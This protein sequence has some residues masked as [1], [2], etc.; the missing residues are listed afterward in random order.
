MTVPNENLP[1][2][3]SG[4]EATTTA[5]GLVNVVE[6]AALVRRGVL[7]SLLHNPIAVTGLIIMATLVMVAVFADVLAPL[8]PSATDVRAVNAVP[9]SEGHM[10]GADSAGRDIL[11]R[12]IYGSRVTLLGA[13]LAISVGIVIGVANG[14]VAGYYGGWFDAVASWVAN[15]LL[16]LPAMVVLLAVVTAVGPSVWATMGAFG[17]LLS[18]GL[19]RLVRAEV[20]R[21]KKELYVD[22]A[23]VSGLSDLRIISRHVLYVV[24]APIIIQGSILA[25]VAII[26]QSGLE[27]LGVSSAA[28]VTWGAMLED[29]FSV[30][31]LSPPAVFW[32]GLAISV[33]V[34]SFV[35]IG[36]GLRDAVQGVDHTPVTAREKSGRAPT[37]AP[38]AGAPR[39]IVHGGPGNDG[40][41]HALAVSGLRV[42]FPQ[43]DGSVIVVVDGVSLHVD[44]GE[45]LGLVGESGS[46]K[47]QT[48]F[49]ILGLL[50]RG[51]QILEGTISINGTPVLDLSEQERRALLGSTVGY[52]PQEP[53]TNLDP[54]FTVGYQL[55]EPLV[56]RGVS[57]SEARAKV[58]ALLEEV[59]IPDPVRTMAAYPHQVS[60]G[61]AQ[62]VLIAGAIA[63]DPDL[64]I[65]DEPTTALDVTVQAEV[66]ALLRR[67]QQDRNMAMLLVTHNFGV[68]ADICD[69]VAVMQ[70]G[71]IVEMAGVNEL[72]DDPRHEYTRMLLDATLDDAPAR[73]PRQWREKTVREVLA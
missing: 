41:M 59:G 52:I 34:A 43:Q 23:R 6:N 31:Y 33:T 24:R 28:T 66:L 58:M 69:R 18:P 50:S 17:V 35:L 39:T 13:L 32:P 22:A 25:G 44:K 26:V 37:T 65:A 14:L 9:G 49:A 51:G 2:Q 12:L 4:A 38:S 36:N 21:V 46:G 56:V 30:L 48:A 63:G 47:S 45:V 5:G 53:M 68:V 60:G 7:S 70:T 67:L 20:M 54:T 42:G 29:A 64:L 15:I 8:D 10:L 40:A 73:L 11:S 62:R 57:R 16:S 61:M 3:R 55:I 71:R 72:F 1:A 19:F 27:F